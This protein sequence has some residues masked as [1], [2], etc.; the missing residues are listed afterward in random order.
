[1]YCLQE[2]FDHS[3]FE[4]FKSLECL[5]IELIFVDPLFCCRQ[6]DKLRR[7]ELITEK[8]VKQL[9]AK[10][11]FVY[12][13]LQWFHFLLILWFRSLGVERRMKVFGSQVVCWN[14]F[15]DL[16]PV[17]FCPHLGNN[18]D[19]RFEGAINGNSKWNLSMRASRKY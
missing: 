6:I 15:P 14:L 1:M 9:C 19:K 5:S 4:T 7:C 2:R 12:Y 10:A 16:H 18:L 17:A 11:R 8:E 13:I 3:H